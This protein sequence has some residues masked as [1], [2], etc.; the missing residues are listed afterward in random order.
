MFWRA[1]LSERFFPALDVLLHFFPLRIGHENE[2]IDAAQNQL[3]GGVVNYLAGN[4]V[5][6]KLGHKTLDHHCV[7]REK[8]EK[9]C[10]LGGCRQRN[11]VAAIQRID[12]LMNVI[13]VRRFA[14]KRGTVVNDFELNLATR[15]VNDRHSASLAA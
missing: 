2:P 12:P 6:L 5:E 3:P 9:E 13:Q 11:Q 4:G 1:R 7:E 15:V 8:I 14:A 10:A